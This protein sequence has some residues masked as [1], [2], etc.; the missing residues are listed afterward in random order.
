MRPGPALSVLCAKTPGRGRRRCE[1]RSVPAPPTGQARPARITVVHV[2]RQAA[3]AEG[4]TEVAGVGGK[5]DFTAI[6][7]SPKGLVPRRMPVRRQTDY[8]AIAKHVVLTIYEPQFMADIEI[9]PVE[10]APRGGV[11][12]IPASH[13]RRCTSIVAFGIR[14]LPPS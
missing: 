12:S 8:R 9:A 11:G 10:A 6:E 2:A 14:A 13:S 1:R 7:A 3:L 4:L 5:H